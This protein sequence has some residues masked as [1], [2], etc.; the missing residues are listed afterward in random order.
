[1]EY[2]LFKTEPSISVPH[3]FRPISNDNEITKHNS[4][5]LPTTFNLNPCSDIVPRNKM[6]LLK[7]IAFIQFL[8]LSFSEVFFLHNYLILSH[9]QTHTQSPRPAFP[10]FPSSLPFFL[11]SSIVQI[12]S[13]RLT[14]YWSSSHSKNNRKPCLESKHPSNYNP[15]LSS[16]FLFSSHCLKTVGCIWHEENTT[17]HRPPT[18]GSLTHQRSCVL[19]SD[20]CL[21]SCAH[22]RLPRDG[23]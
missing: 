7:A 10:P 2:F 16:I 18:M 11:T 23:S 6:S 21:H 13:S 22:T 15:F 9:T 1:M 19:H 20:S 3:A 8:L 12:P 4:L 17:P 14:T 5:Q